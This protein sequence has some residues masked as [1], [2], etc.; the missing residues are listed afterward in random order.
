[1]PSDLDNL[2][3]VVWILTYLQVLQGLCVPSLHAGILTFV[4]EYVCR[5]GDV[6]LVKG[7]VCG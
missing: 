5:N 4:S 1:M 2:S 6:T 7:P 3:N